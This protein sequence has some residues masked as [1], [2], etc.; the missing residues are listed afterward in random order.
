MGDL[1]KAMRATFDEA[2]AAAPA[3]L[4]VDE[5]D[6]FGDRESFT[7]DYKDYSIQVVN[8]FL[9]LL[10][11]VTAREGVIVVGACNNPGR[12]DGAI[13]R[14]GRLDRSIMIPLPDRAG[15][16][17]I[18]RVHLGS[19]LAGADLNGA[20]LMMSGGTGA[21]CERHVRVAR[22]RARQAGRPMELDDLLV[23]V[24]GTGDRPDAE[25]KLTAI[26]EAGHAV[27]L[28]ELR[29]GALLSVSIQGNGRSGGHV[30]ATP[31]MP[32]F[33]KEALRDQMTILLSGRAA[34]DLILGR[35]TLGAGGGPESDIARATLLAALAVTDFALDEDRSGLMWSGV[36]DAAALSARLASDTVLAT[37]VRELLA[38][39]YDHARRTHPQSAP[40]CGSSG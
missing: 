14:S 24:G 22:R 17:E 20:A 38:E 36:R 5:I 12:L 26:H 34:E 27:A 32:Y 8:G 31:C 30:A 11:G 9:E 13:V 25:R 10:D 35:P 39:A 40:R 18:L 28:I 37:R 1:L 16:A 3:I 19:D 21:D 7:N 2:R 4:F 33:S 23:A 6:G 29:P 15:L